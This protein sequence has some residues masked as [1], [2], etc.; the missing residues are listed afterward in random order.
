MRYAAGLAGVALLS[1]CTGQQS[2]STASRLTGHS[3]TVKPAAQ[4]EA[5]VT[6]AQPGATAAQQQPTQ[7]TLLTGDQVRLGEAAGRPTVSVRPQPT[8]HGRL[9]TNAALTFDVGG[10]IYAIPA[11]ALPYL[12][13][14][15]DPRLFD[16][17]YLER[18]GYAGLS[19]LPV[20]VTWR[21]AAHAAVPGI[22]AASTGTKTRGTISTASGSF[23]HLLAAEP[24]GAANANGPL[25]QVRHITLASLPTA[26]PATTKQAALAQAA[27][28][29]AIAGQG[30]AEQLGAAGQPMASPA[31][32]VPLSSGVRAGT[33]E[34]YT[35]TVGVRDHS[36]KPATGI[37]AIQ[38]LSDLGAFYSIADVTAG[39]QDSVS[40]PAGNYAVEA[41]SVDYDSIGL[42]SNLSLVPDNSVRVDADTSISLNAHTAVPVSVT[43]P[44]KTAEPLL[45]VTSFT[46]WSARG[47]SVGGSV[48][49]FGSGAADG[50]PPIHMY[51]TPTPK[52]ATGSLGY[53]ASY[54]LVPRGTG[55]EEPEP[56]VRYNYYLDFADPD[57]ISADQAQVMTA[58]DLATVHNSFAAPGSGDGAVTF[59]T[60]FEPW[61]SFAT[62][63]YSAWYAFPDPDTRTDYFGGTP[64]TVWQQMAELVEP[65]LDNM[66]PISS[67]ESPFESFTPG[68]RTSVT[69]GASPAVPEPEWQDMGVPSTS[70]GGGAVGGSSAQFYLCPVCR[71]GNLLSFNAQIG[72]TDPTHTDLVDGYGNGVLNTT[73]AEPANELK[74]YRNGTLAQ[75]S[76]YSAQ[77]F[78]L[79]PGQAQ[80]R[81]DWASTANPA[82]NGMGTKVNSEW[83]FSSAPAAPDTLP[84][85]EYCSPDASQQCSYV[86]L[87]FASY[88][89]GAGLTGQVPAGG[90]HTFTVSAFHEAG[91]NGP[92]ITHAK[93]QVS[94]DDGTTWAPAT[95][96]GQGGGDYSV[97]VNQPDTSG[98]VSV[99]VTLTDAAGDSLQQT[100]IRAY[101]LTTSS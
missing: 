68:T 48:Q 38:D 20:T 71:E 14:V 97:T 88:D 96:T 35:L 82:W 84:S 101:A 99:R 91:D 81:I 65:P 27:A 12:G 80:Y 95:V 19:S 89:F 90:T 61:A 85:Y 11:D 55:V 100:I 64:G 74:F 67:P 58:S 47:G 34:L 1:A 87:V 46:R 56:D 28:E 73:N 79:L 62:Q 30:A 52:P 4:H 10:D 39:Q 53:A 78:P 66:Y 7:L 24:S 42:V 21:H 86:P 29:Q 57:G 37:V 94:F 41:I 8:G 5:G 25:S 83:T 98:Y 63:L 59:S 51:V 2:H 77:V 36:G 54:V 18:A 92:A 3:G 43:V 40:L 16:V 17:S 13:S 75:V 23:G 15:L 9:S 22:T 44:T 49:M 76:G 26:G 33:R 6:A 93:V 50:V 60:P 32:A 45:A 70:A 31:P 69:W 72:D